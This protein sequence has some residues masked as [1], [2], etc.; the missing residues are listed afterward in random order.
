M[1]QS[2]EEIAQILMDKSLALLAKAEKYQQ[3][4]LI[5]RGQAPW[6]E[7]PQPQRGRPKGSKNKKTS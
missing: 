4:A 1:T 6:G 5:L 3:A 7:T 2:T